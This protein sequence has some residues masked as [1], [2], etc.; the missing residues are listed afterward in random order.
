MEMLYK[1]ADNPFLFAGVMYLSMVLFKWIITYGDFTVIAH[2]RWSWGY[3]TEVQGDTSDAR[4][5]WYV[6]WGYR[7]GGYAFILLKLPVVLYRE[8]WGF[9]KLTPYEALVNFAKDERFR[10]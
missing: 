7:I 1:I 4:F 8:R 6:A 9:F 10:I 3:F 2:A 5:I